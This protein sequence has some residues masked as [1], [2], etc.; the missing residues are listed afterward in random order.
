MRVLICGCMLM[1]APLLLQAAAASDVFI[2]RQLI[3]DDSNPPSTPIFIS[4]IPLTISQIDLQ[5]QP[6]IDDIAVVG[7]RVYRDGL[8]IATTTQTFYND[9]GL[10]AS[11]THVYTLDAYDYSFNISSTSLGVATTT[12]AVVVP[13]VATT[14]LPVGNTSATA[15]PFKRTLTVSTT[16]QTA[17]FNITTYGPTR[18]VVRWGRTTSYELGTI[19]SGVYRRSHSPTIYQLEPGTL[20]R[21]ELE[22]LNDRES[23]KVVERG[24]FT[25]KPNF[26][27]TMP[28]NVSGLTAVVVEND[29]RLSWQ[30]PAFM[31]GTV[32]VVR[33]H[34]FYPMSPTDGMIVYDGTGTEVIDEEA[35]L[36]HSPQYYTVFVQHPSGFIS[37]GAIL[38]VERQMTL[39]VRDD[40]MPLGTTSSIVTK[41]NGAPAVPIAQIGD[42]TLLDP[43]SIL[44]RF[45][46]SVVTLDALYDLPTATLVTVDIP[47][48]A[49]T[50]HLKAIILTVYNPSI[51]TESTS[52]LLKLDPSGEYYT[53]TFITAQNAGEAALTLGVYDF[54]A[55]VVRRIGTQVQY[56]DAPRREAAVQAFYYDATF[57]TGVSL[58]P[59]CAIGYV[60]F[61]W[62]RRR[63]REDN[64]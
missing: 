56:T 13:P 46:D 60:A 11:T 28:S 14:T 36:Q 8:A 16:A 47:K 34:L 48:V 21:Y 15:A 27:D 35:L 64:K 19:S 58:I 7:Y 5:W 49:V 33:S 24:S 17:T 54:M 59:V 29:V 9:T 2:V 26:I 43:A 1:A 40:G 41:E 20:Y 37:S 52:Y 38:K 30:L 6:S 18:Y 42:V 22:L 62:H 57:I 63:R 3:G 10:M 45:L 12:L 51:H 53:V 32:R 55:A 4:A 44:V 25:T 39:S 23:N 50:T 31:Q 61:L